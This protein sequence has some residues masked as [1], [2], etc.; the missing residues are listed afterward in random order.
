MRS[1]WFVC[2]DG[3]ATVPFTAKTIA[4]AY[5]DRMSEMHDEPRAFRRVFEQRVFDRVSE[6]LEAEGVAL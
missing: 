3:Y 2:M 6:A 4:E 5:A 1:V